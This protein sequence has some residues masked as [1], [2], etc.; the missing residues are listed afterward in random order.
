MADFWAGDLAA[1]TQ[2]LP[3]QRYSAFLQV[4]GIDFD[5]VFY[6]STFSLIFLQFS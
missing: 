3:P 6:R 1:A 4:F 2:L 5:V